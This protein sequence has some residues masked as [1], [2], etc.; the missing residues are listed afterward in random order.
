MPGNG[1]TTVPRQTTVPLLMI[2]TTK[3]VFSVG[4]VRRW[5]ALVGVRCGE[6]CVEGL[7]WDL[8]GESL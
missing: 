4:G 8:H 1:D 6:Q 2:P 3:G 5:G 7:P